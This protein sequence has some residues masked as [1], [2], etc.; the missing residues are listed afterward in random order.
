[1][2]YGMFGT[3]PMPGLARS[4]RDSIFDDAFALPN[5]VNANETHFRVNMNPDTRDA[6]T[7]ATAMAMAMAIEIEIEIGEFLIRTAWTR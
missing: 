6:A 7:T 4:K 2:K 5:R 3:C 1:M